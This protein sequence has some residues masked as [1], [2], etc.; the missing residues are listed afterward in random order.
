MDDGRE[1]KKC[2]GTRKPVVEKT[3][4]I[5][6]YKNCIF[7]H[8]KQ[9]RE[10]N[11]IRSRDQDLYTERINKTALSHEDDKRLAKT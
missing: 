11:I 2:K 7:N 9:K 5:E 10:T 4:D 3:L 1:I 6:D 8:Q